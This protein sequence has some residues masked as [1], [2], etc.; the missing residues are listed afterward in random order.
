[1]RRF[2]F[3]V[4]YVIRL[5]PAQIRAVYKGENTIEIENELG[6]FAA[7]PL[8]DTVTK[9]DPTF[10]SHLHKWVTRAPEG[11]LVDVGANVGFYTNL[12]LKRGNATGVYAFEPNP[13][14]Y[15]LLVKNIKNNNLEADAI[16]AAVSESE[17][18]LTL[19]PNTVH[20]G[21][22]NVCGGSGVQVPAVSF[23]DFAGEHEIDPKSI[24]CIKID[25]EGHELSALQ[26][27]QRTLHELQPKSRLF[28]EIWSN[29]EAQEKTI[30][31]IKWCGF[32]QIDQTG[33]NY[34][35]K[36]V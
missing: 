27:M 1:M 17:G 8:T 25:V 12:A 4:F 30:A 6:T 26:G 23:D 2:F 14:V 31:F 10:E 29:S 20:T 7:R 35:F 22:S 13:D 21:A 18:S 16:H 33:D 3:R 19:A 5:L 9:T 28:V 36:K 24:S 34:L 15:P 11:F 32:K